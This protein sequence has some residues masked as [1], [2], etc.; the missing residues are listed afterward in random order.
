MRGSILFFFY[1]FQS[2]WAD[3]KVQSVAYKGIKNVWYE[4]PAHKSIQIGNEG[5]GVEL[6]QQMC[7]NHCT[8]EDACDAYYVESKSGSNCHLVYFVK[9]YG[10]PTSNIPLP[11]TLL[12]PCD[13]DEFTLSESE[14]NAFPPNPMTI[15]QCPASTSNYENTVSLISDAKCGQENRILQCELSRGTVTSNVL[16]KEFFDR[17]FTKT[18]YMSTSLTVETLS[19]IMMD[20][21]FS[22]VQI[23]RVIIRTIDVNIERLNQVS[24]V[25][26]S[27]NATNQLDVD[28][29]SSS[30]NCAVM[31]NFA[32]TD[33]PLAKNA[34]G[35]EMKN[36]DWW[37]FDP[38]GFK[39]DLFV[40]DRRSLTS[41]N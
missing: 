39:M 13:K 3:F 25:I 15:Y 33:T 41:N 12:P 4:G 26:H 19:Y 23:S 40:I 20:F 31:I 7:A 32:Y 1:S 37:G 30:L 9:I 10:E 5:T 36:F 24:L 18:A 6:L 8:V 2:T 28:L 16:D 29:S 38:K 21:I 34:T 14:C 27:H 35:L 22:P 17:I 11:D